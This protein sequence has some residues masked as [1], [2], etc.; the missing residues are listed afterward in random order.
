MQ[1]GQ[2]IA[3]L[4]RRSQSEKFDRLEVVASLRNRDQLASPAFGFGNVTQGAALYAEQTADELGQELRF[5]AGAPGQR[6]GRKD[7]RRMP[8]TSRRRVAI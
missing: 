2:A 6:L 1:N 8:L 5:D 4:W 3:A 7:R